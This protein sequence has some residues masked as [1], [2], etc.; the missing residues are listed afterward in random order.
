M[1]FISV[2]PHAEKYYSI[3]PYAYCKGNPVNI[4][5]RDGK[6]ATIIIKDGKIIVQAN[7]ILYSKDGKVDSKTVSNF[8]KQIVS[9]WSKD[10]NGNARTYT[11]DGKTYQVSF[12]VKITAGSSN[13][14][15]ENNRNYD[16]KNN[17]IQVVNGNDNT[18]RSKVEGTNSGVWASGTNEAYHEF[19]HLLGLQDR[20]TDTA[21]GSKP[22]SG[23]EGNVMGSYGG[24]VEQKNI[25]AFL[26]KPVNSLI[27]SNNVLNNAI[28]N[29]I[30]IPYFPTPEYTINSD[31]KEDE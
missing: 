2:D 13:L 25:N 26:N 20:Y 27:E 6:D 28:Q 21:N 18:V 31:D 9:A 4:I 5:D 29:K 19:G 24:K 30:L 8:Q 16:G 17:Y 23:Y 3:S 22:N 10:K 11:K 14:A 7:I 1:I 12:D 15:N